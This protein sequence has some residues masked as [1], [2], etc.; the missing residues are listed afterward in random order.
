LSETESSCL[1]LSPKGDRLAVAGYPGLAVLDAK[2]GKELI[3]T[4]A[5]HIV[6]ALP[7]WTANEMVAVAWNS[8]GTLVAGAWRNT[9]K[10]DPKAPRKPLG[11]VLLD[12]DGKPQPSPGAFA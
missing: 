4:S 6:G 12:A 10:G 7:I 9:F 8:A 3:A 5:E 11:V 2:D 1:A